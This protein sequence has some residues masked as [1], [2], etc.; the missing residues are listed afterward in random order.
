M[1]LGHLLLTLMNLS[2]QK[3]N[4]AKRFFSA[5]NS[6]GAGGIQQYTRFKDLGGR[7]LDVLST[8]I[9]NKILFWISCIVAFVLSVSLLYMHMA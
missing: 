6:S 1:A 9:L 3:H 7:D 2:I 8:Y 4:Q 5:P